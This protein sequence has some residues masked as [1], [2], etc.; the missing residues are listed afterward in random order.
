INKSDLFRITE[1]LGGNENM[2]KAQL[3]G[4]LPSYARQ[5]SRRFP[6]WKSKFIRQNRDWYEA[7][8][9]HISPEWLAKVRQLQPSQRKLEWNCHGEERNIWAHVLQFRPSGLRVK[10]ITAIPA[11][12]SLTTSQVPIIGPLRRYITRGEALQLQGFP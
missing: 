5:E 6:Y 8:R 1:A 11:L 2:T 7:H 12:V 4:L 9:P 10:R 3:L